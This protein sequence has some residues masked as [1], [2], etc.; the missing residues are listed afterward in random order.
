MPD[1]CG[2]LRSV[3][4]RSGTVLFKCDTA[5][6]A[7]FCLSHVVSRRDQQHSQ[8]F[9]NTGFVVHN[10]NLRFRSRSAS[11]SPDSVRLNKFHSSTMSWLRARSLVKTEHSIADERPT[12][13]G[14]N[15]LEIQIVEV[16]HFGQTP[17]RSVNTIGKVDMTTHYLHLS[18]SACGECNGPV[19]SA[20]GSTRKSEIE[21]QT[22]ITQIGSMC[23]SCGKRYASLPASGAVRHVA[24]FE[25]NPPNLAERNRS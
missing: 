5:T 24:P 11:C 14:E 1:I 4:I 8:A 10:E 6:N 3:T 21:R 2:M 15:V 7:V 25:W 16:S 18:A 9:P 19:I 22:N 12:I 17:V 13:V 23:L 20:A